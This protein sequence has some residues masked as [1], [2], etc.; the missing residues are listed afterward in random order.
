MWPSGRMFSCF[1]LSLGST[2]R[3]QWGWC[4]YLIRCT[5]TMMTTLCRRWIP[6]QRILPLDRVLFVTIL[7]ASFLTDLI[8]KVG[9]MC[10]IVRLQKAMSCLC[11]FIIELIDHQLKY[12]K[13]TSS[14]TTKEV[15]LLSCNNRVISPKIM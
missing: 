11:S 5:V 9:S 13:W 1:V 15:L 7:A 12:L 3:L 14:P 6:R 10:K 8:Y 4:S 2:V